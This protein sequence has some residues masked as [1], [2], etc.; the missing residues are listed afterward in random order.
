MLNL[1]RSFRPVSSLWSELFIGQSRSFADRN[2]GKPLTEPEYMRSFPDDGK[3]P[4][5]NFN[6]FMMM[7]DSDFSIKGIRRSIQNMIDIQQRKDQS[8]DTEKVEKLGADLNAAHSILKVG[9]RV[10]FTGLDKWIERQKDRIPLPTNR[11]DNLFLQVA[12]LTKSTIQ[13][14]GL[15]C[16]RGTSLRMLILKDCKKIDDFCLSRLYMVSDTLEF[17]DISGCLQVTDNGIGALQKLK[18]LKYLRM[19]DLPNAGNKS[20]ISLLLQEENPD[21]SVLGVD[22][23]AVEYMPDSFQEKPQTDFSFFKDKSSSAQ[24]SQKQTDSEKT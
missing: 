1:R 3:S 21:L 6:K 17:L 7:L 4:F 24:Q 2:L 5:I 15:E 9:G 11:I 14:E 8:L 18:N 10:Q 22:L 13:Y 16:L 23:E 12:D 20:Y 19:N